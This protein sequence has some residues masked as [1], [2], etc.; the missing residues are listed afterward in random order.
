MKR[1]VRRVM[2]ALAV[3]L[4]AAM[5]LLFVAQIVMR[6]LGRPI[7]WS[8]EVL[9]LLMIWCALLTAAFL[10][11]DRDEVVFDLLHARFPEEV[12]RW[13]AFAGAVLAGVIF[14]T[15]TPGVIDYILFL[16]FE[17]TN[18]LLIPLNLAFS[19]FGVFVIAVVVRRGMLALGLLRRDWRI[20]LW[21]IEGQ[22]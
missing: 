20:T 11:E 8:D 3:L 13:I 22:E 4:F 7:L 18:I 10:I 6:A 17:T 9:V 14:A 21:R 19:V 2:E 5:L 12:R 1:L 15:A 16:R